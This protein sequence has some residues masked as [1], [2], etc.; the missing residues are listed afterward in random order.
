MKNW[1][2]GIFW[3]LMSL[4]ALAPFAG[5]AAPVIALIIGFVSYANA[6]ENEQ[7][8]AQPVQPQVEETFRP[9]HLPQEAGICMKCMEDSLWLFEHI[10]N[11]T[12]KS[13]KELLCTNCD[14]KFEPQNRFTR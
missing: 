13:Y 14:P 8:T 7:A 3:G 2:S 4:F 10:S 5:P 9:G 11:Q 1:M 12:G 6:G